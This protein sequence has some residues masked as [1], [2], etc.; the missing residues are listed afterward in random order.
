M[1][2][3]VMNVR[4][5]SNT[6]HFAGLCVLPLSCRNI[7]NNI[8]IYKNIY[9][10]H[11]YSKHSPITDN[12]NILEHTGTFFMALFR[13]CS[14]S[15]IFQNIATALVI[16]GLQPFSGKK[17]SGMF[18]LQVHKPRTAKTHGGRGLQPI[19]F[20]LFRMFRRT[21]GHTHLFNAN[22]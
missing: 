10:K 13:K 3:G 17:C 20:L 16:Q 18:R 15:A 11:T 4:V 8:N 21:G 5:K 6:G 2:V 12:R 9:I 19:S 14:G 22:V 7:R 1:N